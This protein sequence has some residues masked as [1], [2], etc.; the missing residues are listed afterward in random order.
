MNRSSMR[1]ALG[2]GLAVL[3]LVALVAL[4]RSLQAPDGEANADRT[5]ETLTVDADDSSRADA[6]L[7]EIDN[8][9]AAPED[10]GASQPAATSGSGPRAL[11]GRVIDA[12]HESGLERARV[13]VATVIGSDVEAR[14][15]SLTDAD[16]GFRISPI[17][18]G[19]LLLE[20]TLG[21]YER[22]TL[23]LDPATQKL[24]EPVVIAMERAARVTGVVFDAEGRPLSG[25]AVAVVDA[26]PNAGSADLRDSSGGGFDAFSALEKARRT[27]ADGRF[28]VTVRTSS[29]RADGFRVAALSPSSPLWLS[30]VRFAD[31]GEVVELEIRLSMG[32]TV[33]GQVTANGESV[34]A[35]LRFVDRARKGRSAKARTDSAGW[36]TASGLSPGL[37]EVAI[38]RAED[39]DA[40]GSVVTRELTIPEGL[41]R[42]RA[43]FELG[44]DPSVQ[45][46]A[47]VLR[48]GIPVAGA[49]VSCVS[50]RPGEAVRSSGLRQTDREGR[51]TVRTP[52]GPVSMM[53]VASPGQGGFDP[54]AP[55]EA[56]TFSV[57]IPDVVNPHELVLDWPTASVTGRITGSA[58]GGAA[59][60]A[61]IRL[62]PIAREASVA[63]QFAAVPFRAVTEADGS[64]RFDSIDEG[65]YAL[66]MSGEVADRMLVSDIGVPAHSL[67]DLGELSLGGEGLDG[68]L[69]IEA[70]ADGGGGPERAEVWVILDGR[71]QLRSARIGPL[72]C[73]TTIAS[74]RHFTPGDVR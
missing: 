21:D 19:P 22:T 45:V 52:P 67:V 7:P 35:V 73:A 57:E 39:W 44:G 28:E 37:H 9:S 70:D 13:V 53:V 2:G 17:P 12:Y 46:A 33:E 36:F 1:L 47:R 74:P 41:D 11:T 54:D 66:V 55:P 62:V 10:P 38:V 14:G 25:V 6:G 65:S 64:F 68:Y 15:W 3:L 69:Q 72:A 31:P 27:S 71:P 56:R 63:G 26:A 20:A 40:G 5:T 30:E 23:T 32:I 24:D 59:G 51:F 58:E 29:D 61:A 60:G 42:V 43:D 48:K 4:M 34:P 49:Q 18:E 8:R 16:G 50:H